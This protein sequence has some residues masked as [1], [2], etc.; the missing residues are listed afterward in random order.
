VVAG[1]RVSDIA[2]S[3]GRAFKKKHSSK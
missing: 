2:S 3:I 1:Q